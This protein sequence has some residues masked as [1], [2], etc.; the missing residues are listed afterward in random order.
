MKIST[1]F[2]H[3]GRIQWYFS[4]LL[5]C[6]HL[7]FT[8]IFMGV[9]RVVSENEN[10][11]QGNKGLAAYLIQDGVPSSQHTLNKCVLLFSSPGVFGSDSL[12]IQQRLWCWLIL[13]KVYLTKHANRCYKQNKICNYKV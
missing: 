5:Y 3:D 1:E 10:C 11:S 12:S 13:L 6:K 8:V 9:G 4:F 7:V 2:R